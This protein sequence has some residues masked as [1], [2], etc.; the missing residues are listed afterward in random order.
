M[1][2]TTVYLP[3]ELKAA[4]GRE[5]QRT[6]TTEAE[7]IRTALERLLGV[8]SARPRPSVGQVAGP[9]LTVEEMDEA[10][11]EGFGIR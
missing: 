7:L 10:F 9:A 5:A 8:A 4:L 3:E 2:K 1:T 11:A 6:H